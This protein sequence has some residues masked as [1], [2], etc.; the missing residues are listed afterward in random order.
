MLNG[1]RT[2]RKGRNRRK[3]S[4]TKAEWIRHRRDA[5]LPTIKRKKNKDQQ[6]PPWE[7]WKF[8]AKLE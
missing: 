4:K 6:E 8:N 2:K 7:K 5:S 1:R 3:C